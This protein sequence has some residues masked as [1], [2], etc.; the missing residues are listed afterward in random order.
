MTTGARI[1]K[2]ILVLVVFLL[3]VGG[4]GFG[5][6]AVFRI[7]S[8]T[9]TPTPNP[10][11]NLSPIS[12]LSTKL[13]N[14]Q[15]NDYDFLAKVTN[16][17][18]EWGSAEVDYSIAFVGVSGNLISQKTDSFYILPGQTKYIINSPLEFNE[19]VASAE[20]IIKS[21][22][23]QQMN[24]QS[25]NDVSLIP[26]NYSYNISSEAGI[27][28]R[29]GG[30]VFNNSNFDLGQV[31]VLVLLFDESNN[32]IAVNKTEILTFLAK[33]TRGFETTWYSPFVGKVGPIEID[34]YTNI[35]QNSNFIRE[36]GGT[37][38]F[39]QLY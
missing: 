11:I 31:S 8:Q 14:V 10:T 12:I 5:A 23:W 34:A 22:E 7:P 15:N 24:S 36:Y 29:V 2:Q 25:I 6:Y 39:Q 27:F 38:K 16:P 3:I 32:P 4:V 13:L 35:F 21:V 37:A 18:T 1:T 20:M 19:Q 33:T 17:N 28:S 9:P 26:R 30:Q